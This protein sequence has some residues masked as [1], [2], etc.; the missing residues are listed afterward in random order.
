MRD[1]FKRLEHNKLLALGFVVAVVMVVLLNGLLPNMAI[2][3]TPRFMAIGNIECGSDDPLSFISTISC[4][5]VGVPA[6]EKIVLEIPFYIIGLLFAKVLPIS[7]AQSFS[8]LAILFVSLSLFFGYKLFRRL[9]V[10]KYISLL[11]SYTYLMLPIVTSMQQFSS[12]YWGAMLLPISTYLTIYFLDKIKDSDWKSKLIILTSWSA[13]S[14]MQLFT[15]GY[16]FMMAALISTCLVFCWSWKKW[17]DSDTWFGIGAFV[18][19][20]IFAYLLFTV[21]VSGA[22]DWESSIDLFRSMGLDV[23]TLFIPSLS[24]WWVGTLGIKYNAT[25]W[26]DGTN[27]AYNYAG[28]SLMVLCIFG[29]CVFGLTIYKSRRG[30]KKRTKKNPDSRTWIL[31]ALILAAIVSFTLSLGPSLKINDTRP[32]ITQGTIRHSDYIMPR[33]MATLDMPTTPIFTRLPGIKSM[34]ATYRWHIATMLVA[35]IFAAIGVQ[36][37][38]DKKR[39]KI[40]A[41]VGVIILLEFTPNIISTVESRV[42]KGERIGIFNR[43][44]ISPLKEALPKKDVLFYPGSQD[45]NDYLANYIGPMADISTYNVGQDKAVA[46]ARESRPQEIRELLLL[47]DENRAE[48]DAD[49][50][51]D[52]LSKYEL[53]TVVPYFDM[54]WDSYNWNYDNLFGMKR[55]Q[56][57]LSRLEVDKRFQVTD[58]EYFSV[59]ELAESS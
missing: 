30:K 11:M 54:R 5:S 18:V 13:L 35:L 17:R 41:L 1:I 10:N 15:D 52:I 39:Y 58:Y 51:H 43:Q 46:I 4:E 25:F 16:T 40:A 37:F 7:S 34:R 22:G 56:D 47:N 48:V 49:M 6:G 31:V 14:A 28:I 8:L 57:V 55:A 24:L 36:Y 9:S 20:Q 45:G 50:L 23:A 2:S 27:A 3:L 38:I 29:L 53:T 32:A 21:L 42:D 12:L 19:A 59:V 26:G 44:V 33:N